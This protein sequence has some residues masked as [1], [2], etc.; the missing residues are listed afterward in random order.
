MIQTLRQ[1]GK[2]LVVSGGHWRWRHVFPAELKVVIAILVYFLESVS[3][4]WM[5]E[6]PTCSVSSRAPPSHPPQFVS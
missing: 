1:S 4:L 3:S 2:K 6:M 5:I